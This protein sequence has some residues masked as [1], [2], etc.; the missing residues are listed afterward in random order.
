M[1]SFG[2]R[3]DKE[4]VVERKKALYSLPVGHVLWSQ[5]VV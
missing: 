4:V 1:P 2:G 3:E 5:W